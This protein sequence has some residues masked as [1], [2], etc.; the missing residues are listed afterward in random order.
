[1]SMKNLEKFT[2]LY[3]LS[4]LGAGGIAVAFFAIFNYMYEHPKGLVTMSQIH[5]LFGVYPAWFLIFL[6]FVMVAFII[7]HFVLTIKLIPVTLRWLKTDFFRDFRQD[8]M[9]NAALMAPFISI[10]MTMNVFIGPIRYLFP[11]FSDNLQA[12]MLPG[13]LFWA[14]LWILIMALEIKLLALSFSKGFDVAKISFGWLLHPFA[15]AMLTVTG[16]GMAA[17]AN[18]TSLANLA[19]FMSV[20]SGT[21]GIFLFGVKLISLFKSHFAS[22]ALPD[23][24]F[25]PSLLIVVP[26]ITLFAISLFRLGHFLEKHHGAELG[27]YFMVVITVAFALETW[28]LMFGL[29]LLNSYFK[30]HL[31]KEFH[32]SQWGLIC[33]FV[34]YSV[35]G[36]F[37]YPLFAPIGAFFWFIY[38]VVAFTIALFLFVLYKQYLCSKRPATVLGEVEGRVSC[39]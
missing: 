10:T 17:L 31:A 4:S 21:M 30:N 28:Y 11:V 24:Q 13:F 37:M 9:R 36:A 32:V 34:A 8:P 19:A 38:L 2:P 7:L 25:L 12:M 5:G 33:P 15:L 16:T 20:V 26:N 29:V 14:F 3:W 23:K 35:L 6:E 22:E 27:V 18:D 1:M 39:A